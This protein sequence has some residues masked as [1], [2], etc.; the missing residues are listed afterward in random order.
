[1][2]N[3]YL[4]TKAALKS[5]IIGFALMIFGKM[6]IFNFKDTSFLNSILEFF[7][8]T[9]ALLSYASLI[10][11]EAGSTLSSNNSA[12]VVAVNQLF[13]V[14]IS[15][16]LVD[17]AGRKVLLMTSA[18]CCTIGLT[19]FSIYDFTKGAGYDISKFT[20]IPLICFSFVIFSANFGKSRIERNIKLND[21]FAYILN[22]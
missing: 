12:I 19:V 22:I 5:T 2:S 6:I 10:F 9:F 4:G 21:C 1:M 7:N 13:G 18:A 16:I 11:D 15:T 14:Y 20:A 17:R 3:I 8:G